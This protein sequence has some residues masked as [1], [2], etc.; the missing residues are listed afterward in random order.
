MISKNVETIE[1]LAK[2]GADTLTLN[3]K[4]SSSADIFWRSI[5]SNG[6]PHATYS[7]LVS[8]FPDTTFIEDGKFTIIH[9]IIFG[10]SKA[11]L[12]QMLTDMPHLV[13]QQDAYGLA[14]LHWAATR[15]DEQSISTL[16]KHQAEVDIVE[17][18]GSTP[19]IWAIGSAN[20]SVTRRLLEAGAN[21]NHAS[22]I[23]L[24]RAIYIACHE[25]QFHCQIPVLL[26]YHADTSASSKLRDSPLA[27]AASRDFAVTVETLFD[28][29]PPLKHTT[30]VI[31]AVK[32]NALRSLGK[33]MELGASCTGVDASGKTVLHHA[34]WRGLDPTLRLLALYKHKFPSQTADNH[35]RFPR[36]YAAERPA[37]EVSMG[38]VESLFEIK[39]A[40][41]VEMEEL[42]IC[43]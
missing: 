42:N 2:Q 20:P 12:D 15:G 4:R 40:G 41:L 5:L 28:A 23:W 11:D 24:D 7:R 10:Q 25:E 34:A 16:L 36:E 1:F 14:P 32:S 21:P 38:A 6:L 22:Y 13:N 26:E 17:R 31:A 35:G 43:S 3:Q 37:S 33:L 19:L 18:G 27:F 29:T 30:A 39:Q 8:Y 9:K